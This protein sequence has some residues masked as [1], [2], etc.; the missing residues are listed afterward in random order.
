MNCLD[1]LAAGKQHGERFC[2]DFEAWGTILG[3]TYLPLPPG[4]YVFTV[5]NRVVLQI[6]EGST[7]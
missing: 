1:G 7:Y 2:E 4:P 5:N 6:Q 3:Q